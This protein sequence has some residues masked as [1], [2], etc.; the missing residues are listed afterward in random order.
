ML[1]AAIL[2][3]KRI[4]R[5]HSVGQLK[6]LVR[7]HD[8]LGRGAIGHNKLSRFGLVGLRDELIYARAPIKKRG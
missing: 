1:L 6:F 8:L 7:I 3:G 4:V 2:L 5:V